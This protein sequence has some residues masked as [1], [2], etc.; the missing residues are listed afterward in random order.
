MVISSAIP[1]T[2]SGLDLLA[3]KV[4]V[5]SLVGRNHLSIQRAGCHFNSV[6]FITS[7]ELPLR[8]LRQMDPSF[9]MEMTLARY[10]PTGSSEFGSFRAHRCMS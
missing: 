2:L 6:N 4:A 9:S 7:M 10:H 1:L 5:I 3:E 8:Y